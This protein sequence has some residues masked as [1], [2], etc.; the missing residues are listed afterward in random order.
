M[1]FDIKTIGKRIKKAR[2]GKGLTQE[3]LGEKLGVT[4]AYIS[5]IERGRTT[6]S[7]DNLSKLSSILEVSPLEI[8]IGASSSSND[9]LRNEITDMIKDCSAE[10]I[11]LIA[12]VIK[13]IIE[14]KEK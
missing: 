10:K 9:Y 13:P 4:G 2:A 3:K 5:K 1:S 7:L 8:L 6:V 12:D 14:Y 11:R